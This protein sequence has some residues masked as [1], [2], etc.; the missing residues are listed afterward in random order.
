MIYESHP[1]DVLRT[2]PS[3]IMIPAV[4][5]HVTY[6]SEYRQEK[7]TLKHVPR[8]FFLVFLTLHR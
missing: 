5:D 3:Q 8:F 1:V 4:Q 6:F 2:L 7:C